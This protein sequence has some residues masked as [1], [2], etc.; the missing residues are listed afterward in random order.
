MRVVL[1]LFIVFAS[2]LVSAHHSYREAANEYLEFTERKAGI[3]TPQQLNQIDLSS[4]YLLNVNAENQYNEGMSLPGSTHMD[5]RDVLKRIDELPRDKTIVVYCNTMLYS[6]RAQLLLKI[7]GLD[8]ILLLQ[9]G[10][11]HYKSY[12]AEHDDDNY[13]SLN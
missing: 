3:I 1:L 9:G 8:N 4:V 11:N 6:S 5:W 2:S 13:M 10:L 7:D 12:I